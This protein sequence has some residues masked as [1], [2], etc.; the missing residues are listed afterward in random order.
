MFPCRCNHLISSHA[1]LTLK[2]HHS[3][4]SESD[5]IYIEFHD[6]FHAA[7]RMTWLNDNPH[8]RHKFFSTRCLERR[9]IKQEAKNCDVIFMN[10]T[11][12]L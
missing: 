5:F 1:S 7:L 9:F 8:D 3:M 6:N 11:C 2:A 12:A 4:L 10:T